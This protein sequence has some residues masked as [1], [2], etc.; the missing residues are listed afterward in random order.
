MSWRLQ[1]EHTT[2]FSYDPTAQSS[3]NEARM[4]PATLPGQ[5]TLDARVEIAPAAALYRYFDYW[6]TQVCAFDI[7]DPHADL[8]VV[9]RSTVETTPDALPAPEAPAGWETL[10]SPRTVDRFAELLAPTPR[11]AVDAQLLADVRERVAGATPDA[12]ARQ[13]AGLVHEAVEYV[14]GA[15]GVQTSAREAWER[16]QGVCQDIAH[17]TAGL[18]RGLGIPARYVSGYVHPQPDAA[19]GVTVE[20]QSHAWVEWWVGDWVGFDPT[21]DIPV[22]VQHVVVA[23]GR[24][25]AD[26]APLKG[27]YDG[28]GSSHLDVRVEVTRLA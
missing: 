3:Y 28:P 4:T 5:T 6:G 12:A 16:R 15:T 21:N 14:P 7:E 27:V 18:L 9:S 11:T 20:G 25:Y 19:V 1:I 2:R 17:L 13:V 23:R 8:V 24:D 22:G 10:R 26:V